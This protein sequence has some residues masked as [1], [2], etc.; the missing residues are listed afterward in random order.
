MP[1]STVTVMASKGWKWRE[2]EEYPPRHKLQELGWL[3]HLVE[4]Q[5]ASP[6]VDFYRPRTGGVG[7]TLHSLSSRGGPSVWAGGFLVPSTRLPQFSGGTSA[8]RPGDRRCALVPPHWF[9]SRGKETAP[10]FFS[11]L[12]CFSASAVGRSFQH[13]YPCSFVSVPLVRTFWSY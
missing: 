13:L 3:C 4:R 11:V 8:E 9:S 10:D 2:R 6:H 1:Q 7:G 5:A 12:F